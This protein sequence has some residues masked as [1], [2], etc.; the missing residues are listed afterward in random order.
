MTPGCLL[1]PFALNRNYHLSPLMRSKPLYPFTCLKAN[2]RLSFKVCSLQFSSTE[3]QD[4]DVEVGDGKPVEKLEHD[5]K[6][7]RW[8]C[9][10]GNEITTG[11]WTGLYT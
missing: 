10:D 9:T 3:L 8:I 5:K 4:D 7:W 11:N 6:Y 2:E 1:P